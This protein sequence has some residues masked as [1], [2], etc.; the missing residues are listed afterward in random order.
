MYVLLEFKEKSNS[1][2]WSVLKSGTTLFHYE[3][4]DGKT[5]FE[6]KQVLMMNQV[7][8]DRDGLIIKE[9]KD[10][11]GS[12]NL[13]WIPSKSDP[14]RSFRFFKMNTGDFKMKTFSLN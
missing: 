6:I 11:A 1:N 5:S 7:A 4:P 13:Y 10:T 14:D 3:I 8:P 2:G 9:L 12:V